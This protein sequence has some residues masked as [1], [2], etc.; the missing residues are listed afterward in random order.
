MK[1]R[2]LNNYRDLCNYLIEICK[3]SNSIASLLF[4]ILII[5]GH[6]FI[7]RLS[8]LKY[9]FNLIITLNLFLKSS[10]YNLLTPFLKRFITHLITN[11]F[12]VSKTN[13]IIQF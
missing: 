11:F 2:I 9:L 13:P 6:S 1:K 8:K 5:E 12:Q 7:L 3:F 4:K 10:N